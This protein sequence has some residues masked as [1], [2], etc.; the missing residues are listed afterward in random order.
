MT[1]SVV[2]GAT[3]TIMTGA[4][5]SLGPVCGGAVVGVPTVLLLSLLRAPGPLRPEAT[6]PEPRPLRPVD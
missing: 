3:R 1:G 4:G 6:S 2:V 5:G